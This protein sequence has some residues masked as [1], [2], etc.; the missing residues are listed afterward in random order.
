MHLLLSFFLILISSFINSDDYINL[1]SARQEVLMKPLIKAFENK[2]EV[3]VNII[4]AKANQLINRIKEE[5]AYTKADILLTTDVARL[6]AAKNYNLFKQINNSKILSKIPENLRDTDNKWFALSKRARIIVYDTT[7]VKKD[8]LGG[9]LGLMEN[10]WINKIMVR[11]SNNV[12]NQSLIA[13]MIYNYG[14]KEIERFLPKFVRNFSRKPSGGDRDQIR[15]VLSGEGDIA[16]VNSYYFLKMKINDESG[17]LKNLKIHF[18]KDNKMK[19][20]IN[21]SGLGI[22]KHTKNLENC[23]KFL[24]FMLST[25]AQAIYANVNYE[26]PI[27]NDIGLGEKMREYQI[28]YQDKINLSDFGKLNDKAILMMDIAGWK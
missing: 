25:D 9:Y 27:R 18:P 12:Y 3:K 17:Q 24:D 23:I 5:G 19:T 11:S 10:K 2:T 22:I 26:Y 13:A 16:L 21:I 4:A 8:L 1:Y 15:G 7:K 14:E 20:H 28:P 6:I